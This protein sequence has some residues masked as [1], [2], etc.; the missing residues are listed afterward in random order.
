MSEAIEQVGEANH[1]SIGNPCEVSEGGIAQALL[2]APHV[3]AMQSGLV[4]QMLLRPTLFLS[5]VANPFA[6]G[7]RDD[8]RTLRHGSSSCERCQRVDYK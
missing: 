7:L 4:C 3:R 6:D 2:H 8:L 1:Q 5:E